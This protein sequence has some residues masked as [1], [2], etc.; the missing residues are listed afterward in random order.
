VEYDGLRTIAEGPVAVRKEVPR[1]ARA[2]NR[3]NRRLRFF[4]KFE[5]FEFRFFLN[6]EVFEKCNG[7]L[8]LSP[9]P[10]RANVCC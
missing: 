6:F 1:A 3:C 5:F 8:A 10:I 2:R 7:K 9:L 4:L